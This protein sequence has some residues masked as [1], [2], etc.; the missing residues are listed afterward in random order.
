MEAATSYEDLSDE[1]HARLGAQRKW[2]L[3]HYDDHRHAETVEGKLRLIS[4]IIS[5][6]WIEP[7]E[8]WKLQ[9]LGIVF[10]DALAQELSLSWKVATDDLG[11]DPALVL[12][13][14]TL[15][16]N[17]LTMISK[18]IER[19]EEVDVVDLF[20]TVCGHLKAIT[21]DLKLA[22]SAVTT[23]QAE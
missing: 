11:R 22:S 8:T 12:E 10:G 3:D 9:S 17:P 6:K 4:V 13:G 20:G 14:T 16:V 19:G 2:V 21:P 1:D 5:E 7:N 15:R 18:R 23:G